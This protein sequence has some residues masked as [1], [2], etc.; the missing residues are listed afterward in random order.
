MI[1]R[2]GVPS[3][4]SAWLYL[5][6][7]LD[8]DSNLTSQFKK[9]SVSWRISVAPHNKAPGQVGK[10]GIN[11]G[12]PRRVGQIAL[13]PHQ[14]VPH[15]NNGLLLR[16][17]KDG[18]DRLGFDCGTVCLRQPHYCPPDQKCKVKGREHQARFHGPTYLD[19]PRVGGTTWRVPSPATRLLDNHCVQ[20]VSPTGMDE[21]T[22]PPVTSRCLWN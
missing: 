1:E 16:R 14:D 15:K 9:T 5:F 2:L 21:K 19:W 4:A 7:P 8:T 22:C 13:A 11:T 10:Y 17:P 18:V 6:H 12:A 20:W 3:L